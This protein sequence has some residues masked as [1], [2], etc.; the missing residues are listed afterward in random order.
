[1]NNWNQLLRNSEALLQTGPDL[2][3]IEQCGKER[4]DQIFERKAGA[5]PKYITDDCETNWWSLKF[6]VINQG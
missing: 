4:G 2:R 3:T 5:F 6:K 1:M